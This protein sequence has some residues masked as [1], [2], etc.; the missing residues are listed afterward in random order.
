MAAP[1]SW[2]NTGPVPAPPTPPDQRARTEITA[3]DTYR[4][5]QPVWV[6]RRSWCP[7][8]VMNASA[9][10]VMV[11]YLPATGR[12]TGVDTVFADDLAVRYEPDP[13]IDLR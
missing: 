10:A 9:Q 11:R 7:G 8:V 1:L 6:F 4:A 13:A 3:P 5:G 2:G 12:G